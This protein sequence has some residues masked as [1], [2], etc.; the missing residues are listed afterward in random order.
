[1]NPTQESIKD[2]ILTGLIYIIPVAY[3]ATMFLFFPYKHAFWMDH[4]EGINLVKAQMLNRGYS[5]Y[6]EIW[7]DQPP[8]FTYLIAFVL[9]IFN[10]RADLI[11]TFVLAISSVLMFTFMDFLRGEWGLKAALIGAATLLLLPG[12][13]N[14][15][16]S[17]MIGLPAIA[18]AF[19][20]GWALLYWH[21]NQNTTWLVISA[22]LMSASVLTKLFTGFM[23]PVYFTGIA[24]QQY[25]RYRQG[26]TPSKAIEPV[27]LWGLL[28]AT[29]ITVPFL[30]IVGPAHLDQLVGN[31]IQAAGLGVY[32]D[33]EYSLAA[34]LTGAS[35]VVLLCLPALYFILK[36]KKWRTLY[37]IAWAIAATIL[38][39]MIAPVWSHHLL[40]I[41]IPLALL[42]AVSVDQSINW[43]LT[44]E[45]RRKR[46]HWA[47]IV[48]L[49]AI[50]VFSYFLVIQ[51]PN[52][53]N[54][55]QPKPE[56]HTQPFKPTSTEYKFFSEVGTYADQTEWMITDLPIYAF[57]A[58]IAVPPKLVV[59]SS[60]RLTT[61]N[62]S[63]AD[64]L[65]SIREYEPEQVLLGRYE[66]P[67]TRE[68]LR[69]NY[70]LVRAK[71]LVELY[72]RRDVLTE[73]DSS[74]TAP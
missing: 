22:L 46:L 18:F 34:Q 20:S 36:D 32:T 35:P 15:S 12:Y 13:T 67:K 69:E 71:D 23:I 42:A 28:V 49:L 39:Q 72:V 52:F 21:K 64:I 1:M 31:H 37:L 51:T 44:G 60:K 33:P 56:F 26:L 38:L 4:D 41:T 59:F 57:Y 65:A 14:L 58:N 25:S 40:L 73:L 70:L 19:A 47:S 27:L 48:A 17:V 5:L 45:L 10:S 43:L 3:F 54:S 66:F 55:L 8:L 74:D 61:G 30:I 53:F 9:R 11:R 29:A 63:E 6:S 68:F 24:I 2:K 7:N 50:G 16:V 62:L